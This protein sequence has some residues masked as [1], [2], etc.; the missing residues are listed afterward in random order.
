M[1]IRNGVCLLCVV[2]EGEKGAQTK[3]KRKGG[4]RREAKM[5]RERK[6]EPFCNDI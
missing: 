6:S 5:K 4:G 3:G 2:E 1:V